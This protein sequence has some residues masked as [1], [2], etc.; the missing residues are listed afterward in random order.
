MELENTNISMNFKLLDDKTI[1]N[2]NEKKISKANTDWTTSGWQLLSALTHS[3][4][5]EMAV[6]WGLR[7]H[8]IQMKQE[9]CHYVLCCLISAMKM[10]KMFFYI[11][12]LCLFF[13]HL[14]SLHKAWRLSF[15]SHFNKIKDNFDYILH[16]T[17]FII[18][19]FNWNLGN[20]RID[21]IAY[22]S[23]ALRW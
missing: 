14:W 12:C 13:L 20:S 1:M 6:L 3:V 5:S 18:L 4:C 22:P 15:L 11:T 2:M 23:L 10:V 16:L 9:A 21:W 7:E 8:H 19:A 17:R